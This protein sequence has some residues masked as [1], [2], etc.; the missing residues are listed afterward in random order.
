VVLLHY[1]ILGQEYYVDKKE[2]EDYLRR[3]GRH[4]YA[5]SL[6][7]F[8]RLADGVKVDY[9]EGFRLYKGGALPV[10]ESKVK[11]KV[12]YRT[13]REVFIPLPA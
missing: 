7:E 11:K 9:L 10:P 12:K 1:K 2:F 6:E 3:L 8:N 13:G 5:G 4:G